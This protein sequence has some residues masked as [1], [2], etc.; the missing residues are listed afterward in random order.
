MDRA[1]LTIE[2]ASLPPPGMLDHLGQQVTPVACF[3]TAI[4]KE[5][6]FQ[7]LIVTSPFARTP[8]AWMEYAN[9]RLTKERWWLEIFSN[10]VLFPN[11]SYAHIPSE[12]IYIEFFRVIGAVAFIAPVS[13]GLAAAGTPV[14]PPGNDN[15]FWVNSYSGTWDSPLSWS[16]NVPPSNGSQNVFVGSV[17]VNGLV[18]KDPPGD[19]VGN[20]C[21]DG[22]CDTEFPFA[23]DRVITSGGSTSIPTVTFTSASG[24]PPSTASPWPI[25]S[26]WSEENS[27]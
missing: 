21:P 12:G 26:F 20:G 2:M 5:R 6:R 22:Y 1:Q 18:T 11:D 8:V 9:F 7:Q 13:Q 10:I 4:G 19:F 24:K 27:M 23:D 3:I 25:R 16:G 15:Y 17:N 14:N